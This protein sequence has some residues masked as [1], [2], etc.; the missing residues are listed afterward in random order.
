MRGVP[1][2]GRGLGQA[3]MLA[4]GPTDP[5]SAAARSLRRPRI[6]VRNVT[7]SISGVGI[8]CRNRL[9]DQLPNSAS[10]GHLIGIRCFRVSLPSAL[11]VPM[12][13]HCGSSDMDVRE[14]DRKAAAIKGLSELWET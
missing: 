12:F 2:T 10:A 4:A 11:D 8:S 5:L 6:Y 3:P 14:M 1:D 13:T 9:A 7:N